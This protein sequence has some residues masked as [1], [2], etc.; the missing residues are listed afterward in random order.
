MSLIKRQQRRQEAER[1]LERARRSL[2]FAL[3]TIPPIEGRT[4]TFDDSEDITRALCNVRRELDTLA[5][6]IIPQRGGAPS[7][8]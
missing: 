6:A 3:T 4:L 1:A 5:A 7:H 2:S 8:A